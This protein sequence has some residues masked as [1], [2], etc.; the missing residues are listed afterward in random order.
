[1]ALP[2]TITVATS[3]LGQQAKLCSCDSVV[4]NSKHSMSYL[5]KKQFPRSCLLHEALAMAVAFFQAVHLLAVDT[6]CVAEAEESY[7][8]AN[9]IS[10]R[11]VTTNL[12]KINKK[13]RAVKP[14]LFRWFW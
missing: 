14:L 4:T 7:A 8:E 2:F 3:G 5:L 11:Y 6:K 9:S 1:V 13:Q 12:V 10:P